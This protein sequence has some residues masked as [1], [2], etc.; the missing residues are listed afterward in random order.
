MSA[1][2]MCISNSST[3]ACVCGRGRAKETRGVEKNDSFLVIVLVDIKE[4]KMVSVGKRMKIWQET[5]KE[6]KAKGWKQR[7]N[8]KRSFYSLKTSSSIQDSTGC[9]LIQD[10]KSGV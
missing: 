8:R 4:K 7:E 5:E 1:L 2:T 3:C 10:K 6:D 9:L